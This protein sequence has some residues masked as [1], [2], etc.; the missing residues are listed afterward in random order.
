[1]Q[2]YNAGTFVRSRIVHDPGRTVLFRTRPAGTPAERISENRDITRLYETAVRNTAETLEVYYGPVEHISVRPLIV[3]PARAFDGDA[4][5]DAIAQGMMTTS[6]FRALLAGLYDR[7]Y[8][9]IDIGTLL[10]ADGQPAPVLVPPGKKPLLFT[11]E[12]ANYYAHRAANGLCSNLVLDKG[13]NVIGQYLDEEGNQ[14]VEREAE[15]IGILEVFVEE[16]PDFSFDGAKGMISLTGYESVFG[17]ICNS[18]Q[19]TRRNENNAESGLA[20]QKISEVQMAENRVAVQT[21][22]EQLISRGWRFASST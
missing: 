12:T 19:L 9:L 16:H 10:D 4:Y 1:M 17:Y 7:G 18:E 6:E 15:A 5:A 3:T 11:L 21:I 22:A 20:Q 13:G 8:V 14:R 2:G